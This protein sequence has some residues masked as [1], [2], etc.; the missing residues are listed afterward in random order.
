M[1]RY[2]NMYL[3]SQFILL[4]KKLEGKFTI[5]ENFEVNHFICS[6]ASTD[7]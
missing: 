6:N 5:T 2:I 7:Y 4:D 1:Y 3:L